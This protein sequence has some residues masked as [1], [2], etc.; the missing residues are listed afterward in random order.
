[1]PLRFYDN[2]DWRSPTSISIYDNSAWR[3]A[4]VGYVYDLGVW[5]VVFP[6][7]IIPSVQ[8]IFAGAYGSR[9]SVKWELRV[10][11]CDYLIAYLYSGSTQSTLLQTQTIQT[12]ENIIEDL[13]VTFDNL[14]NNTTYNIK[15]IGYSITENE[16]AALFSGPLTT[17]NVIIPTVNITSM[18]PNPNLSSVQINWTSTN[19]YDYEISIWSVSDNVRRFGPI[20]AT[21]PLPSSDQSYTAT[22]QQ[23][24]NTQYR[25]ELRVYSNSI[26]TAQDIDF[27][28]TPST[29]APSY[30]NFILT[31]ATCDSLTV[32]WNAQNYTSG[33]IEIWTTIATPER[34]PGKG[35]LVASHSFTSLSSRTFTGLNSSTQYALSLIHI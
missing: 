10:T 35:S 24:P 16:S 21:P 25:V 22:F 33:T 2:N 18:V 15:V 20:F 1:M 27:Y 19:Q 17:T 12:N 9:Y 5:R 3:T 34:V 28:T 26:D 7:P 14:S 11:N 23:Q 30:S 6:D 31:G 8:S 29:P 4:T 13:R 32:S